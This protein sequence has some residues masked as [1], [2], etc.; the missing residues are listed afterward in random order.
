LP[1]AILPEIS[2]TVIGETA[3]SPSAMAF[4]PAALIVCPP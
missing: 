4:L 3:M 1:S 2:Q